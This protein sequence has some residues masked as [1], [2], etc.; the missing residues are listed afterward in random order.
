MEMMPEDGENR[1]VS[2][3]YA[4]PCVRPCA[5]LVTR[6]ITW[7]NAIFAVINLEI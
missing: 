2:Q 7:L 1:V 4:L 3:E 6:I 5:S